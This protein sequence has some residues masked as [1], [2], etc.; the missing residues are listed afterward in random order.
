MVSCNFELSANTGSR[1]IFKQRHNVPKKQKNPGTMSSLIYVYRSSVYLNNAAVFLLER[2]CY[3]QAMETLCDAMSVM[4]DTVLL[5]E[6]KRILDPIAS[7]KDIAHKLHKAA[8]RLSS[9]KP[10]SASM[11]ND[12][13]VKVIPDD[14]SAL[15][16][17]NLFYSRVCLMRDHSTSL[18][19]R[20]KAV[21][22]LVRMEPREQQ[23]VSHY[24]VDA[25]IC[26]Y[27][28]GQAYKCLSE[29][30]S[31]ADS[32]LLAGAHQLIHLA[33]ALLSSLDKDGRAV[34]ELDGDCS[35]MNLTFNRAMLMTAMSLQ[36]LLEFSSSE[37]Q[38]NYYEQR[39]QS[40]LPLLYTLTSIEGE[41]KNAAAGAA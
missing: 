30:K 26:V 22:Y 28:Y 17:A 13:I 1:R 16:A 2:R 12:F 7:Q 24:A 27:N 34:Y 20:S 4:K 39:L 29:L 3:R 36:H 19:T 10:S 21:T 41:C 37:E 11:A 31:S 6:Q 25:A 38:F 5:V 8:Q 40:I 18:F 35:S 9:P 32:S 33:L 15:V 14:E 23:E